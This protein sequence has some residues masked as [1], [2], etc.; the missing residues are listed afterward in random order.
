MHI[1]LGATG[2]VGSAVAR[3]LLTRGE[4]VTVVTRDAAKARSHQ[5]HGAQVAVVDVFD[6]EALRRVSRQ[7][8]SLFM[9]NP[10]AAPSTD[11]D[12]VERKS[13]AALLAALE[14]SGLEK[15]V[16]ESTYGA[17]PGDHMG[18]LSVLYEMEQGLATQPIP[19]MIIRAAYYMSNWESALAPAR[20]QGVVSSFFPA[21]FKLP[22]VAPNDIG[23][24][25]ARLLTEPPRS[26]LR[27]VE[28]P[29]EYSPADVAAAYAAALKR[30]VKVVVTPRERWVEEFKTMGFSDS[31]AKSYVRMTE[32][33]VDPRFPKPD[34]PIR[35]ST[36]LQRYVM[37]LVSRAA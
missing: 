7:G 6:A 35:G 13:V 15:I 26:G 16:A 31:A 4:P 12:A 5:Q 22:M 1:I 19:A 2:H 28:G 3:A 33:S 11:T 24:V 20:E 21:D 17:Q 23:E 36:T 14:S 27:Y 8:R 18:D 29:E 34:K 25:A 10:P 9:L 30:P 32:I 37:D